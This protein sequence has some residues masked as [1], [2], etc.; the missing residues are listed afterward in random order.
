MCF[1][2]KHIVGPR[3]KY[4]AAHRDLTGA[5]EEHIQF[6]VFMD[7][8]LYAADPSHGAA[9]GGSSVKADDRIDLGHLHH[10]F[11]SIISQNKL[12]INGKQNDIGMNWLKI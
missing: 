2:R 7:M 1:D 11:G 9:Q 5:G 6:K 8:S 12:K 3:S 4:L 10:L